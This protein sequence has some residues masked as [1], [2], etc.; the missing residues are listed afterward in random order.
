M[1]TVWSEPS[2]PVAPRRTRIRAARRQATQL[3]K[4]CIVGASGYVVNL[5]VFAA[6][7]HAG[8]LHYVVAATCSFFVAVTNN[9]AWNRTWTFRRERGSLARQGARFFLVSVI[10]LEANILW[11]ETLVSLD[12]GKLEAQAAAI[13]LVTPVSFLGNKLWSFRR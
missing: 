13:V 10:A 4:F 12:F 5:S 6:L 7:V 9:Y 1:A 2:P 3:T 8:A 11:L